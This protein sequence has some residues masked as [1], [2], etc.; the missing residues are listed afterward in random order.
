MGLVLAA[1][2]TRSLATFLL[3]VSA[4][5]P[6]IFAGVTISLGLAALVASF[7]PARRALRVDPLVALRAD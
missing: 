6:T 7:V 3:G 5:D 2:T 4:Y 1:A